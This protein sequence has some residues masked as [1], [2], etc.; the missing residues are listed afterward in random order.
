MLNIKLP[1]YS[2]LTE[3]EKNIG[4]KIRAAEAVA[5]NILPCHMEC[6]GPCSP[7]F[8]EISIVFPFL[9]NTPIEVQ[10]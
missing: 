8:F 6:D 10:A 3:S 9:Y 5:L 1:D 7:C 4:K 2:E